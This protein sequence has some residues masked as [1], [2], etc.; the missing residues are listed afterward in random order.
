VVLA[1]KHAGNRGRHMYFSDYENLVHIDHLDKAI[2]AFYEEV[3]IYKD[4]FIDGQRIIEAG[5]KV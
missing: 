4:A 2:R 5:A 1:R 3:Y